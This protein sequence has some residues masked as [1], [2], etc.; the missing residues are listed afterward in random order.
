MMKQTSVVVI[1]SIAL[2]EKSGA[3]SNPH[4]TTENR[5]TNAGPQSGIQCRAIRLCE[6]L[7][8]RSS[9]LIHGGERWLLIGAE[10]SMRLTHA[11]T[12]LHVLVHA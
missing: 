11:T 7:P 5:P 6:E 10:K 12:L 3:E 4:R 9:L 2:G 8:K 1:L